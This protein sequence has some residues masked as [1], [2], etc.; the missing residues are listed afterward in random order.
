ME[1]LHPEWNLAEKDVSGSE[2]EMPLYQRIILS[3]LLLNFLSRPDFVAYKFEDRRN[4]I[5]RLCVR[6]G[7]QE[8]CWTIRSREDLSA[9][10]K[11]GAIAIFECFDPEK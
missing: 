1:A 10:E 5:N 7:V 4:L 11:D 3:N 2:I 9:A 8:V 6:R